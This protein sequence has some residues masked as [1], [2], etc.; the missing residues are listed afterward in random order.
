MTL[1]SFIISLS[2]HF[3]TMFSHCRSVHDSKKQKY[4]FDTVYCQVLFA[5]TVHL[6][7]SQYENP[8]IQYNTV[9]MRWWLVTYHTLLILTYIPAI[10]LI[11][12]HFGISQ[13]TLAMTW[14]VKIAVMLQ[15][16]F[17]GKHEIRPQHNCNKFHVFPYVFSLSAFSILYIIMNCCLLVLQ[18]VACVCSSLCAYNCTVCSF[19]CANKFHINM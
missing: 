2:S 7:K 4:R 11:K 1:T 18:Y 10:K 3:S 19:H 6:D 8:T 15:S 5:E 13:L 16:N 17:T 9:S 14:D 12:L